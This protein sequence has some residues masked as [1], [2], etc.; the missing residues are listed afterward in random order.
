M[1]EKA[2][3]GDGLLALEQ[4]L[5]RVPVEQLRRAVRNNQKYIEQAAKEISKETNS[6]DQLVS[7]L[8]TLKRKLETSKGEEELYASRTRLRLSHLV[9]LSSL[10]SSSSED[11]AKWSKVRLDRL[12]IDYLLRK[13]YINTALNGILHHFYDQ[14]AAQES[15]IQP[16]V[17]VELF[18]QNKKIEQSLLNKTCSL[19]LQWCTENKSN[20]KKSKSGLEFNLRLQEYVEIIRKGQI[21]E[22]IAYA[23]KFLTPFSESH[24]KEIQQATALLAFTADT[25]CK[26]YKKFFAESRWGDL[27]QQFRKD[28]YALSNL[29]VEPMLK[30]SLQAG[31]AALKTPFC[32]RE[33]DRNVN[34]PVCERDSFGKLA[35]NL[36]MNHHVN[37]CIVCRISGK[38]MDEDNP[39]MVLP[40]G[41]VY[42]KEALHEMADKNNGNIICPR[43]GA[44]FHLSQLRKAFIS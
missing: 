29:P 17:D 23:R 27:V 14:T 8:H 37:S 34:C 3:Q 2:F 40:N 22:A 38:I 7:R 21:P 5:V 26:V 18:T 16:L 19:C 10:E 35:E 1:T 41:Y 4:P 9:D 12:V 33:E 39:P 24:I 11:F 15:N 20:L 28:N 30:I 6:V 44:S 25:E 13:G 32:C 36:P 31:L 42:S 43:S